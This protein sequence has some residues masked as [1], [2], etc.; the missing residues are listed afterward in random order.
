MKI[1]KHQLYPSKERVEPND[2]FTEAISNMTEK[3]FVAVFR[4][5]KPFELREGSDKKH[6]KIIST[7]TGKID[8][9]YTG[10][11]RPLNAFHRAI[12]SAYTSERAAGNTLTTA[13]ILYRH[14]TGKVDNHNCK[15]SKAL[16]ETIMD[17]VKYLRALK[18]K[19]DM[20]DVCKWLGYNDKRAPQFNDYYPLLPCKIFDDG[21]I[22]LK[23]DTAFMFVAAI[24][25][26]IVRYDVT[27]LNV[28]NQHSTPLAI[29]V[30]NYVAHRIFEIRQHTQLAKVITFE[31]VFKKCG[32][33][34]ADKQKAFEIRKIIEDFMRHLQN[35]GV[36]SIFNVDKTPAGVHG[37]NFAF[38]IDNVFFCDFNRPPFPHFNTVQVLRCKVG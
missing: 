36:I 11:L 29:A 25:N 24:K 16:R 6:G 4:D 9:S 30:R 1:N 32:L 2:A 14:I 7:L 34:G 22:S 31:D 23:F 5:R 20:S 15:P 35:C 27:I 38:S 12:A 33:S 21:T 8:N 28:P 18:I 17:A 37:L 10:E 19:L 3:D 13:D 26:Q